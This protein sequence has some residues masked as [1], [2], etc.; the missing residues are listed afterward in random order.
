MDVQPAQLHTSMSK[1]TRTKE[2]V[3][4]LGAFSLAV[5]AAILSAS[6]FNQDSKKPVPSEYSALSLYDHQ[7]VSLQE[8]R[9]S[10]IMLMSWATWC[11]DCKQELTALE[12]LWHSEQGQGLV[13]IAVN[14][15]TV[16]ANERIKDMVDQYHLT[17]PIW[18]DPQNNFF[19]TFN[20]PGIPTTVLLDK[21]GTVVRAWVGPVDFEARDVRDEIEAVLAE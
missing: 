6:F 5:L 16:E 7:V 21:Q 1:E 11:M 17:Y 13:V 9:G 3:F 8:Y 2:A 4:I 12:K 10:T 14:L 19:A 15:D 20:A 18:R